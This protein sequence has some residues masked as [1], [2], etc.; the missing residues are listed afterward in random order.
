MKLYNSNDN[1]KLYSGNMLDMLEVIEPN[2]IDSI[3]TELEEWLREQEIE[4]PS[5]YWDLKNKIQEL[6]EKYK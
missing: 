5:Y 3:V 4:Y 2:T 1:Y 6:K